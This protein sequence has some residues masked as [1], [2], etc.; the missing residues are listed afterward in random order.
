MRESTQIDN[1]PVPVHN[2][3]IIKIDDTYK[4]KQRES[5]VFLMN[6]AHDEAEADSD[7]YT[8][9]E[10]VIRGGVVVSMPRVLYPEYDWFPVENEINVGDKVFWP[11]VNFFNYRYL[12]KL[13]G[14]LFIEVKY[15]DI[16]AKE[17]DGKPVPVNGFYLFKREKKKEVALQFIAEKDSE[18]Y[19]I[20]KKPVKE[21]IYQRDTF[22]HDGTW[23]VGDK[24][25]LNVPPFQLEAK[26]SEEFSEPYY[27]A[28]KRHI[29][30]AV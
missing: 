26:T 22:N 4:V 18:W 13:N 7:G 19:S 30:I 29:L 21:V 20:V 16:H 17:I 27:L 8:L 5:G 12:Y 6:A 15:Y 9:S 10:F 24:C 2:N 23:S 1:I 28:Q 3:V 11:I 25:M 14:E